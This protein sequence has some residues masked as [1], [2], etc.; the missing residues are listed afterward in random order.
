MLQRGDEK[1]FGFIEVL[2]SLLVVV[3]GTL[4]MAGL[5][6]RGLQYS[7]IA[8]LHSVAAILAGDMLDRIRLNNQHAL[9]TTDYE[10]SAST[11][12]PDDCSVD[13]Y[14]RRC[15]AGSC[16]PAQLAQY[17]IDQWKF[18]LLCQLPDATGSIRYEDTSDGRTYIITLSFRSSIGTMTPGDLVLRGV[19]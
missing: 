8:Y 12:M 17:D 6:S 3:T 14:P 9:T 16:T 18:H 4:G 15:E 11:G 13:Q 19:L 2:I 1:G 10:V 7:H 5:H